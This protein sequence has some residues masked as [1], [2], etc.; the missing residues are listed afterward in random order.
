MPDHPGRRHSLARCASARAPTGPPPAGR[1]PGCPVGLG[2]D[3]RR[4]E[5]I[6]YRGG[7]HADREHTAGEGLRARVVPHERWRSPV[8]SRA[9]VGPAPDPPRCRPVLWA[10]RVTPCLRHAFRRERLPV[11]WRRRKRARAGA[12]QPRRRRD[13]GRDPLAEPLYADGSAEFPWRWPHGPRADPLRREHVSRR[14]QRRRPFLASSR[15]EGPRRTGRRA[16]RH[17]APAVP[18]WRWS[19]LASSASGAPARRP[20]PRPLAALPGSIR[21]LRRGQ[22]R[23]WVGPRPPGLGG[24]S[25]PSRR[26]HRGRG[27]RPRPTPDRSGR[28]EAP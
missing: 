23:P 7:V 26:P 3:R 21:R 17:P 28:S 6:L 25:P 10:R 24:S 14:D 22:P 9:L 20:S 8:A 13:L 27:R 4:P 12:R 15:R 18:R 1:R 16:C 2:T 5:R 11:P 19:V